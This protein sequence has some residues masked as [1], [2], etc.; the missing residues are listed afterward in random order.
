MI[1]IKGRSVF[2][3]IA[4]GK[5]TFYHRDE[6]II[7]KIKVSDP[8]L[9]YKKYV[10]AKNAALVELGELYD[11]AR[12]SVG[13]GD[14]Q[15]F[16]IHQMLITDEQYDSS[17]RTKILDEHFN[18]DYAVAST[19][20]SFAEMLAQMDSEYMQSRAADVKD[21]SN[22]L[23]RHIL[24][25]ADKLP[26]L[27]ENA[28]ICTGDLMPS[29]TLLMD[30]TKIKGFCTRSGSVNSHTAILAKNLGIP[31]IVNV[32]AEL[33]DEYEGKEAVLDG[34]SGTLYIEPDEHTLRQLEYKEAVE[35]R[36]K[37][38][39]TR[40]K[41]RKNIT[42]DG[43]EIKIYAN[44]LNSEELESAVKND[45][46]GIGLFR[47]EFMCFDRSAFPDEDFQ[48]YTYRKA[49]EAMEGKEVIIGTYDIGAD[50]IPDCADMSA[51]RNPSM[52]CRGI[53]FC[54]ERESIFKTQLRALYRASV[55]GQLSILLPMV[56]DVSEILRVKELIVQVKAEL[57]KE[58]RKFADN[59]KLGAMI[60]TPAA[61]MTSDIIAKEVDFFN[62]GTN[63]LEQFAFGLDR[64]NPCYDRVSPKNHRALLR[65]I[66]MVCDNAHA[67][68][69]K[70]G[71]CGEIAGDPTLTEI[72]LELDVDM[73]SV[74]PS[75]ILPL[76]KAVRSIS[77]KD[78][79]KAENDLKLFL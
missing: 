46:G 26:I 33:S 23:L 60:E 28:I 51:E 36:K 57:I 55:Y 9:E 71:I 16:V 34:Y 78:P 74:V 41:G 68:G 13:E 61:V 8:E 56:I 50:K 77:L 4:R 11:R 75:R 69:I 73:L 38:L 67:N 64:Q 12:L 22:R 65:M 44:I 63:D 24:N 59:V 2:G 76:R 3:S 48:F 5:L 29:E 54:L 31:A 14:A 45:A 1:S 35:G 20:R 66:K 10:K 7:N 49:L 72:F 58:G 21:V 25:C 19:S 27:R 17:I 40:L 62:I 52:G 37:E 79:K 53:R 43:H 42:R 18:A 47:T 39:L 6:F 70:A 30:K 15:I 32:G